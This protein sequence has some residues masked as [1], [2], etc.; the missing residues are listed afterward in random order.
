MVRY[1]CYATPDHLRARVLEKVL[2]VAA[3][4]P[5]ARCVSRWVLGGV[6]SG[7]RVAAMAAARARSPLAGFIMMSYP[8]TVR[9]HD[10][11][12]AAGWDGLGSG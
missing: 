4:C 6:G 11:V 5:Y 1:I 7:G 12:A 3:T 10:G 8:L 2:D 9:Q